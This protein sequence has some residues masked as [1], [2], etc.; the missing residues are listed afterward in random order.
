[1]K[2]CWNAGDLRAYADRELPPDEAAGLKR[3]L[4]SCPA[5]AASLAEI[6]ARAARVAALLGELAPAEAPVRPRPVRQWPRRAAS[7]AIAAG[8]ALICLAPK[9]APPARPVAVERPFVALDNDPIETG[10]VVRVALGPDQVLADVIV[11]PDGR[12]RAYRLVESASTSEGV[13]TE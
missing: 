13:K 4:E 11:A 8:L 6:S 7:F 12:P 3:H 2:D 10:M 1:M 5:C 9:P